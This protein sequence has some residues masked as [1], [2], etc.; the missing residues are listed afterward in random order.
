MIQRGASVVFAC[1]VALAHLTT[2]GRSQ[3]SRLVDVKHEYGMSM[4]LSARARKD[5]MRERRHSPVLGKVSLDASSR[6][7]LFCYWGNRLLPARRDADIF[8]CA[9]MAQCETNLMCPID[10]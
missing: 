1:W 5:L 2:H 8:P 3:T 7:T 4:R 9:D 10:A 6:A